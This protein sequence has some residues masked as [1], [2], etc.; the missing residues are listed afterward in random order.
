[1]FNVYAFERLI[2]VF[3]Y[4]NLQK[5]VQKIVD[6]L[7]HLREDVLHVVKTGMNHPLAVTVQRTE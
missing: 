2:A 5:L 4:C 1:M 6:S 3:H 7:G